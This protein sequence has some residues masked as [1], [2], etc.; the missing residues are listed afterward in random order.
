MPLT[1]AT[2]YP[3]EAQRTVEWESFYAPF[4]Y[5]PILT[6][7]GEERGA[8]IALQVDDGDYQGDSRVLYAAGDTYGYLNFGWGSCSGCDALQGC[9][10]PADVDQLASGMAQE[11]RWGTKAEMGAF[12]R[13]HDWKGDYHWH[14]KEMRRFI[15]E[16][17]TILGVDAPA[18][19]EGDR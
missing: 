9:S 10:S 19:E 3:E 2:L 12:F 18:L 1:F 5:A 16:A 7:I 17:C 14:S 15:R 8:T 4:D 11:V 13:D 6:A